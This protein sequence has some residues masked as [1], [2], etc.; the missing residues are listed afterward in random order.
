MGGKFATYQLFSCFESV[1][2]VLTTNCLVRFA[3]AA[4]LLD[5]G[6]NTAEKLAGAVELEFELDKS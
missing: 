3:N 4:V 6:W 2:F 5:Q 1:L